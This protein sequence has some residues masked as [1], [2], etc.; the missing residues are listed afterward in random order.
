[1]EGGYGGRGVHDRA[2]REK[3]QTR[4]KSGTL[5]S[6]TAAL[7]AAKSN[8]KA[9]RDVVGKYVGRAQNARCKAVMAD[10]VRPCSAGGARCSCWATCLGEASLG[11]SFAA[12]TLRQ[13]R[14]FLCLC[15]CESTAAES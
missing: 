6:G 4:R 14:L 3:G 12:S 13:A 9:A 1:M 8:A 7:S 11:R 10:V 5:Q 15:L 2:D